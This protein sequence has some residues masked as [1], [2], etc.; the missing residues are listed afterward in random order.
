MNTFSIAR[1]F[2]LALLGATIFGG[3]ANA[4]GLFDPATATEMREAARPSPAAGIAL[5]QRLVRL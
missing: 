3:A 5:R 4:A 2:A 1:A